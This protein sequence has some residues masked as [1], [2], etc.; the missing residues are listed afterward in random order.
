MAPVM[1]EVIKANPN[2]RVVFKEFPIRGPM[3]E[4][5][6]RAALA[7]N[8]Q[9]KYYELSHAMLTTKQPLTADNVYALAKEQGL[10]LERLK[11]DMDDKSI[12]TQLKNNTK[13]AQDLK[14]FGTPAFFVGKTNTTTSNGISYVPG[15]MN[16]KQIQ[17]LIDQANG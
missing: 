6:A 1:A 2:V 4:F 5:A 7:A 14:L 17:K 8:K 13:L 15:Q 12:D 10:D 9:G 16:Q 11:K 3:S